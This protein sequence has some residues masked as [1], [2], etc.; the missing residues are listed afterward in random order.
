MASFAELTAME[1]PPTRFLVRGREGV[2]CFHGPP[3]VTPDSGEIVTPE[4]RGHGLHGMG[5]LTKK[6]VYSKDGLL[7]CLSRDAGTDGRTTTVSIHRAT[8]GE[9]VG[10]VPVSNAEYVEF[11]PQGTYLV[12]W[13]RPKAGETNTLQ[14]WDTVS[15]QLVSAYNQ[16]N[17][18]GAVLQWTDDESVCC[19]LVTNE[20][21]IMRGTHLPAGAIA[22][23]FHKGLTSYRVSPCTTVGSGCTIAVFQPEKGGK[24][25]SASLYA[26]SGEADDE[27][28]GPSATRSMFS[29]SEANMLWNATGTVVLVHTS[30][31]VDHS[32]SSYYGATGLFA[33]GTADLKNFT[34][35]VP[36]SKDGPIYDVQW[37]PAGDKF[38]VAAGVMPSRCTLYNTKA[39]MTFN[40]GEAHRN[41]AM[42]SPHGRFLMLAGFGNLAGEMD[43]YDTNK[44]CKKIGTNK[45]HCTVSYGWSPDS[46]YF[47]AATLAPRMNVDNCYKIFKYNGVGPVV[48]QPFEQAFDCMWQPLQSKRFPSRG[49]SP[50][51]EGDVLKPVRI[52]AAVEA[53]KAAPAAYRPPSARGLSSGLADKLK[54]D[55]APVGKVKAE[56]IKWAPRAPHQR[57]IPGMAVPPAAKAKDDPAKLE[58]KKE[59]KKK[60]DKERKETAAAAKAA[61]EAADKEGARIA[62][63][64]KAIDSLTTE[65]REKRAKNLRKKLKNID[66]LK[67]KAAA[68]AELNDDQTAKINSVPDIMA[69][70]EKLGL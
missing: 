30:T 33:L 60:A 35:K 13:V 42:W 1:T 54:R 63:L 43:F 22:R 49:Q 62:A 14:V 66:E 44:N 6:P 36:Q 34:E 39:E 45:A 11:S 26:Y 38:V 68:G 50:R 25:A 48:V 23:C 40:F 3:T 46:R 29:A 10:S 64:P 37:S 28:Q 41:T 4:E 31:D 7:V 67:A 8:S 16:K 65:E 18:N 69:D 9:L 15:Q 47:M 5:N 61:E 19:H 57:V 51:R 20:V 32:N 53:E 56:N 12:T 27:V 24:H 58:A 21:R 2:Q 55:T 59:A 17:S 52:V 70:L